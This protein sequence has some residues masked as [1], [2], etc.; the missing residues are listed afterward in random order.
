METVS[1]PSTQP[2]PDEDFARRL[3]E[4]FDLILEMLEDRI[5]REIDRRGGRYRG[6]F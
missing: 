5:V 6:D 4:N 3:R 2:T 1:S